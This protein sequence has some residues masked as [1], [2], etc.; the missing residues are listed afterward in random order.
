MTL[1][2]EL[3]GRFAQGAMWY[4]DR[5]P[6]DNNNNRIV[7]PVQFEH[8]DPPIP[9]IVDTG[10]P[11]PILD[12]HKADE[13]GI[14]YRAGGWRANPLYIRGF[15]YYGW[16]CDMTVTFVVDEGFGRSL[17]VEATVF[18]PE[19]PPDEAWLHP[20]FIGLDGLLNRVRFAVDPENNLFYFGAQMAD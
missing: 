10:A 5:Y 14:D 13:L 17:D 8:A 20:N 9:V 4:E 6:G 19:L 16:F 1:H 2:D 12:P 15:L 11:W 3:L 7:I 18:I